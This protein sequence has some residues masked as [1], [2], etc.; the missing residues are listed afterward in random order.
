MPFSLIF[1]PRRKIWYPDKEFVMK[2]H[3]RMIEE[4]GGYLGFERGINLFDIVLE[5]VKKEK[6]IHR[7]A[8]VLLKRM[9]DVRIF[10][11]GNHRT[12]FTV[13]DTFLK[14]NGE[15][16]KSTD[17]QKIIMFIKDIIRHD[18][19]EV[20]AWLKDGETKES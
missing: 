15:K 12:A 18:I 16:I 5:E 10:C 19:D 3:D 6:T 1:M 4:F 17:K 20:E 13:T 9:I 7:K 8:A 14:M 2:A 11:D